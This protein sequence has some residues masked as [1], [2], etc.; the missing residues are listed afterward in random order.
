MYSCLRIQ[1]SDD[2]VFDESLQ[3]RRLQIAS[4]QESWLVDVGSKAEGK[5]PTKTLFSS[6]RPPSVAFPCCELCPACGFRTAPPCSASLFV[7]FARVPPLF[8][9]K[10]QYDV[11]LREDNRDYVKGVRADA[12]K[13]E[14]GGGGTSRRPR[15]V[16]ACQKEFC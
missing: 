13:F 2:H 6:R 12:L 7:L 11:Y 9:E 8:R 14:W 10:D 3:H 4:L 15:M 16:L 5:V 1:E